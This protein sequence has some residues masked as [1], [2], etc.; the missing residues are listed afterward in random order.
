MLWGGKGRREMVEEWDFKCFMAFSADDESN[1][2]ADLDRALFKLTTMGRLA[3][4]FSARLHHQALGINLKVHALKQSISTR[5]NCAP[6]AIMRLPPRLP[7]PDDQ[8]MP[9]RSQPIGNIDLAQG[10]MDQVL[11]LGG[12]VPPGNNPGSQPATKEPSIPGN[13]LTS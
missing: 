10:V 5:K 4:S 7:I 13:I 8:A 9:F 6:R 3:A 2:H 11:I 12:I 1:I